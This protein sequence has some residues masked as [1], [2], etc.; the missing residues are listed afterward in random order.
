MPLRRIS[1]G[2]ETRSECEPR[3]DLGGLSSACQ[4]QR[5]SPVLPMDPREPLS[6][7][8]PGS[9]PARGRASWMS[10]SRRPFAAPSVALPSGE[11]SSPV[12]RG[13]RTKGGSALAPDVTKERDPDERR[14]RPLLIWGFCVSPC[15]QSWPSVLLARQQTTITDCLR[16]TLLC[17]KLAAYA[18]M[19]DVAILCVLT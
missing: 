7:E 12:A 19:H 9:G 13:L 4:R 16:G 14:S 1:L 18:M 11:A 17:L 6:S 3:G 10:S 15:S 2:D 5:A 8:T